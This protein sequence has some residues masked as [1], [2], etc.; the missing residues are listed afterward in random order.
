[1]RTWTQAQ[2]DMIREFYPDHSM[3]ELMQML[4]RTA[5]AIYGRADLFGV[6]KSEEYLSSPAAA[7][8]DA[9]RYKK[10]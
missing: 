3:K 4:G 7:G 5:C 2:D 6:K 8:F 10:G 1:M 9:Y